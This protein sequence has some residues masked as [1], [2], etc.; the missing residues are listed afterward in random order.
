[1]LRKKKSDSKSNLIL[2]LS[3]QKQV[4]ELNIQVSLI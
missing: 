4:L 3:G 2:A 1:M